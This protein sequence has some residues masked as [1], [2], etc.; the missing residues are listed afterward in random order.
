[1]RI[2][3]DTSEITEIIDK[4]AIDAIRQKKRDFPVKAASSVV[5]IL[6]TLDIPATAITFTVE[7]AGLFNKLLV[8][9]DFTRKKDKCTRHTVVWTG[10]A[11]IDILKT[12]RVLSMHE[13]V[14]GL[15]LLNTKRVILDSEYT[16]KL[17]TE[18]QCILP[19]MDNIRIKH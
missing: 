1:M 9:N 8:S 2:P 18:N 11:C 5:G 12:N 10:N 4:S 15:E 17:I 7:G 16:D 19:T 3:D 14:R 6:K 13:Y